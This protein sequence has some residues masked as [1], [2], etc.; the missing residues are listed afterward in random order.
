MLT[1]IEEIFFVKVHCWLLIG[2]SGV[3][4]RR[5]GVSMG[6]RGQKGQNL[7]KKGEPVPGGRIGNE[8]LQFAQLKPAQSPKSAPSRLGP[9]RRGH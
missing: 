7:T 2:M 8:V 3:W 9:G 5:Y 1:I 4:C 6:D